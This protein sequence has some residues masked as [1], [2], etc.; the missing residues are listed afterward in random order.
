MMIAGGVIGGKK[1]KVVY[2]ANGVNTSSPLNTLN[3]TN[4]SFGDEHASRQIIVLVFGSNA[5]VVS[6]SN[7]TTSVTVGGVSAA[8]KIQPSSGSNAHRTAWI[9][10][11]QDSG[12]PSGTSGTISITRSVG[13]GFTTVFFV[14]F[15]AYNLRSSDPVDDLLTFGDPA[16]GSIDLAGG[17][18]LTALAHISPPGNSFVWTGAEKASDDSGGVGS[19]SQRSAA[20]IS[21]T[22]AAPGHII[23]ADCGNV[24]SLFAVSWR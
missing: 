20:L 21:P 4:R 13:N 16:S 10:P 6:D 19:G 2:I 8:R 3:A 1:T 9:T 11:R 18:I 15:A 12:G 23:S 17:G 22:T 5:N 7:F 14:A 24:C